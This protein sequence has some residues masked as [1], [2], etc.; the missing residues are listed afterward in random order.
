MKPCLLGDLTAYLGGGGNSMHAAS[1]PIAEKNKVPYLGISFAL[2]KIHQRVTSICSLSRNLLTRQRMFQDPERNH[3]RRR[4]PDQG[5][6]VCYN[7]DW[8]KEWAT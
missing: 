4:T 1:I 3:P 5:C 8:G 2:Y 6:R 7:D